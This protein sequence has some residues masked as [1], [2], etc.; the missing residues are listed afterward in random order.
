MAKP[1]IS[2]PQPTRPDGMTVS[3]PRCAARELL[4]LAAVSAALLTAAA[5]APPEER[6]PEEPA[7][8]ETP[9][10][11]DTLTDPATQ[12]ELALAYARSL[13]FDEIHWAQAKTR[14]EQRRAEGRG[15]YVPGPTA[16]QP[17]V[18]GPTAIA[19]PEINAHRNRM[20]G[21]IRGR[22]LARIEVKEDGDLEVAAALGFAPGVNYV[23]IDGK[24][25]RGAGSTGGQRA[26]RER[27]NRA[28]IIPER[29][30]YPVQE[31]PVRYRPHPPDRPSPNV[32]LARWLS[33]F[34]VSCGNAC[35]ET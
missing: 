31:R 35:C 34:Q 32:A 13:T 24:G 2:M 7:V 25:D 23:W 6:P 8:Q 20:Q 19:S 1:S 28:L 15:P 5:C 27:P 29:E 3:P 26:E 14:L 11:P 22:I 17:Y 18:P 21:L 30:E 16:I 10:P 33:P 9:P 12:R 4:L